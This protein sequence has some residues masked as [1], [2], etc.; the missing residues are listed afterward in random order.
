[1]TVVKTLLDR[2]RVFVHAIALSLA[3]IVV[4]GVLSAAGLV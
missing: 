2:E 3:A 1:V 4:L